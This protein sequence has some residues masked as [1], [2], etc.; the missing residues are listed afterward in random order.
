MINEFLTY[1]QNTLGD[2]YL[3]VSEEKNDYT[4]KNLGILSEYQGINYKAAIVYTYQLSVY[5]NK[6]EETMNELQAWAFQNNDIWIQTEEFAS[7]KVLMAAPVNISNFD[8]L[9]D[10]YVGCITINITLIATE[11]AVDIDY[12]E[13]D[14]VLMAC[15]K[16]DIAYSTDVSNVNKSQQELNET[17]VS[18]ATLIHQFTIPATNNSTNM[19]RSHLYGHTNKNKSYSVSIYFTD[20]VVEEISCKIRDVSYS[21]ERGALPLYVVSFAK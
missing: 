9:R 10:D 16:Y 4:G 20:G 2:K 12:I 11:S 6:V 18:R 1:I 17:N 8:N 15:T 13:I 19:F 14:N 7:V 3:I 5:T 21:S